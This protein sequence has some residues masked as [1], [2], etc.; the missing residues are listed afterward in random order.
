MFDNNYI[1]RKGYPFIIRTEHTSTIEHT[2]TKDGKYHESHDLPVLTLVR[3]SKKKVKKK[4]ITVVFKV[5]DAVYTNSAVNKTPHITYTELARFEN[6]FEVEEV[7]A[8]S[9]RLIGREVT[10]YNRYLFAVPVKGV[11]TGVNSRDGSYS[12]DFYPNQHSGSNVTKHNGKY[13]F[14][15]ECRIKE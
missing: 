2:F 7:E 3:R 1:T 10:V 4:V 14:K 13:F 11:I 15:E 8:N 12:V 6:E 9:E 5:G